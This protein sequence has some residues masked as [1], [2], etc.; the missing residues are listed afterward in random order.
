MHSEMNAPAVMKFRSGKRYLKHIVSCTNTNLPV[1]R[2]PA[3][4]PDLIHACCREGAQVL[5][6]NA[7]ARVWH[8]TRNGYGRANALPCGYA[9]SSHAYA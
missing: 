6:V 4:V 9:S 3:S 5:S 2:G 7:H 8:L 1:K